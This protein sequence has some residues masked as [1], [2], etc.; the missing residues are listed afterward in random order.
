M[1]RTLNRATALLAVNYV[2]SGIGG[3]LDL[4]DP[5]LLSYLQARFCFHQTSGRR[6]FKTRIHRKSALQN[7]FEDDLWECEDDTH[8]MNDVEF[9]RKYRCSR[10][11][12]DIIVQKIE[13]SD[14]FKRGGRGPAQIPVKHQ[15]MLLLHFLG[16]EGESNALWSK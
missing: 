14:V 11:V 1:R 13:T 4:E 6:Y 9:K 5:T 3:D 8:W 7:I 10:P 2:I 15:L 12:L 16:K